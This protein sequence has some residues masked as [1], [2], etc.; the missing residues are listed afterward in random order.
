MITAI[1]LAAGQGRRFGQ[2]KQLMPW[3]DTTILGATIAQVQQS[4]VDEILI[5]TGHD[6][7]AITTITTTHHIPTVH[8]PNY[9]AGELLS[10]LKTGV[11]ALAETVAAALV[12]LA[13]QPFIPPAVINQLIA[14]FKVGAGQLIAPTYR[15]QRGNPVLIGQALFTELLALP[16]E[17]A[18]RTLLQRHPDKLAFV[19]VD[20]EVI[21]LDID[22]VEEYERLR[23]R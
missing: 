22:S 20:T 17:S 9:E 19:A 15:G 4:Q 14:H 10:S 21:L 8:N 16:P 7:A 3:G 5:V 2:T 6:A 13:D 23:P 18:P 11:Q 1:I 12:I